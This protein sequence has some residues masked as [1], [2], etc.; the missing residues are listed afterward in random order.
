MIQSGKRFCS[1]LE[2]FDAKH[3]SRGTE[4]MTAFNLSRQPAQ[5]LAAGSRHQTGTLISETFG[6][7]RRVLLVADPVMAELGHLGELREVIEKAGHD[8][9]T[10]S[11]LA[12]DPKEAFVD[13]AVEL[14]RAENCDCVVGLGGGSA[15]DTAK[16]VAVLLP[17]GDGA[18]NYRLAVKPL[19]WRTVPL[20]TLPTTAGTGSETTGTSII[21]QPDGVKNWF[22]GPPLIPDMAIMDPELTVGLPPFWTFYT[23]MD[24]LVHA[25][26]S[27]TNRYRYAPNNAVAERAI[28]H[29]ISSLEEAVKDGSSIT[30]R[31]G[32]MAAAAHGGT[33][34]GNTGCAVAHNIGHAMGSLAGVPHG[35]AVSIAL[36]QTMEWAAQGAPDGYDAVAHIM[37]GEGAGHVH[38]NLHALAERCGY[39]LSLD[40]DEREKLD[41]EALARA[42]VEPANIDML[43]ATARDAE[44]GD[45]EILAA[46]ALR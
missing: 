14:G 35:R 3:H 2:I 21:S 46:M 36:V 39:G 45:V 8:V 12:S 24:A 18:A 38:D 23:G 44:D 6:A 10:F 11:D 1:T 25:I 13:A 4:P 41:E 19:P 29:G 28:S 7:G 20:V 17:S 30:A 42:M 22:W 43:T 34:I 27:R 15:L 33:A 16:V 9:V 32:M 40:A 31:S 37:G 26:E 5:V